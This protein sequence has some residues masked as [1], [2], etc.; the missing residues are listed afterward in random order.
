M[1]ENENGIKFVYWGLILIHRLQTF[2]LPVTLPGVFIHHLYLLSRLTGAPMYYST[3]IW[4][5]VQRISGLRI[6]C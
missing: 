5:I 2:F 1:A 3:D 4:C 6:Q